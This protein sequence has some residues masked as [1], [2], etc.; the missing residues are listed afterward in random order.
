MVTATTIAYCYRH[1][2]FLLPDNDTT[3]A[4][5]SD[6]A[7]DNIPLARLAQINMQEY[8]NADSDL[9]VCE[10]LSDDDLISEFKMSRNPE[11]INDD[12]EDDVSDVIRPQPPISKVFEAATVFDD[13]F[14]AEENCDE[15]IALLCKLRN[16]LI[17]LDFKKRL[18]A[19]QCSITDFL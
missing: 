1:A 10:K 18:A 8:I 15:E 2:N 5:D 4:S 11:Q 14:A 9:P 17:K 6:D 13:F 19:K 16:K 12:D 3:E 7:D